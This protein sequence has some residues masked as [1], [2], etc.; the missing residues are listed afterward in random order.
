MGRKLDAVLDKLQKTYKV[1]IPTAR[2]SGQLKRMPLDSISMN[3]ILGGG[4]CHGKIYM[5]HGPEAGGKSSLCN[6]IASQIQ[7][8]YTGKNTVVYCDFEYSW[9]SIHATE[10]GVDVDNNFILLRPLNGEDGFNMI[11]D[12]VDTGE[13][14]LVIIDSITTI[15]SKAQLDDSFGGFSGGKGAMV[16]ANG[17]RLLNPYLYNND[18]SLILVSQER[19]NLGVMYGP[20]FKSTGGRAPSY[21]SRFIARVSRTG[22]ILD[23]KTKELIGIEIR[24]RNTKNQLSIPKRDANL[25]LYFKGGI[26]SDDEYID[27]LKTLGLIEQ[28]G[29]YYSNPNWVADDGTIGMKV[30]GLDAVKEFLHKNPILY[31]KVKEELNNIVSNHTIM[32]NL[33]DT[34][35]TE[36]VDFVE[37]IIE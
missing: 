17:L 37:G 14:G 20:D 3:Y 30:C 26:N 32:D 16:L 13:V 11:K 15:A 7:K 27:Y 10:L 2:E 19:V 9:D 18:C 4:W 25:K 28:K 36:D 33:E 31:G 21:Y 8:K 12:L 34:E 1:D 22:D 6:Y 23:P 5:F 35:N 24:V 29:A